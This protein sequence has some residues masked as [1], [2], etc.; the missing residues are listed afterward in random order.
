MEEVLDDLLELLLGDG[1][2]TVYVKYSEDLSQVFLGRP[3]RHD[4]QDYHE[5]S[6][7]AIE[8]QSSLRR[9][10]NLISSRNSLEVNFAVVV[11][12]VH[13]EDVLLQLVGVC[14]R[15]AL[16]HHCGEVFSVNLS[17]LMAH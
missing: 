14:A 2:V 9:C 16:P 7:M 3:V 6:A 12:I 5:L 4:V 11:G 1:S 17:G 8:S 10:A 15:V 13:A